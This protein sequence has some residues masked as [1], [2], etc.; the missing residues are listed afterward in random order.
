MKT[1]SGRWL[2]V[3]FLFIILWLTGCE[4]DDPGQPPTSPPQTATATVAT[5][6]AA[7]VEQRPENFYLIATDAPSRDGTFTD[8]DEFG[9]L[10]GYD[11]ELMALLA[12]QAGFEYEF[13]VT[14]LNGLFPAVA[15]GE[16]D[17]VMGALIIEDQPPEGIVYSEPYQEL[18]QMLVVRANEIAIQGPAGIGPGMR[19][20]VVANSPG[21]ATARSV[22][23]VADADLVL[24]MS[25]A[26]AAQALVNG[27]VVAVV[28][29]HMDAAFYTETYYQ[30]L[31]IAGNQT[32]RNAW[33]S[34]RA[35]G[36][37]VAAEN[38]DLLER[39]N[40]AIEALQSQPDYSQLQMNWLARQVAIVPGESLIG[41]PSDEVVI[42]TTQALSDL[43]PA[44]TVPNLLSWEVKL[45]TMTGLFRFD[46]DNNLDPVLVEF[47]NVQDEGLIY[48]ISLKPDL[49]FPDGSAL[50]A[51]D[52]QFSF[53]R[54]IRQGNFLLNGFLKDSDDDG[55]ADTDSIE[56]LGELSLRLVLDKPISYFTSV[57]ATTPYFIVSKDC[58]P[59]GLAETSTCGGLGPY[60]IKEWLPGESLRLEANPDWPGRAPATP[61]IQIRF[62]PNSEALRT[63]L[64]NEAID[65]AWNGLS[66]A[67]GAELE[68]G[69]FLGWNGPTVFKSYLVLVED[70]PEDPPAERSPW[71]DPRVKQA[72]AMSLDREALASQIFGESRIPL[73]GPI[74][75]GVPGYAEQTQTRNLEE[76]RVIL[77][78]AGYSAGDPLSFTLHY[79][80]DGRYTAL[81]GEYAAL[82]KAQLEETGLIEVTLE[83]APWETFRPGSSSCEYSAFLLG[84]PPVGQPA[85][86]NDGMYWME[87]F[88]TNTE[89]VCSHYESEQM[90]E[91][92]V[93]AEA[94]DAMPDRPEARY[95][96]YA[97][98]QAL[99]ATTLPTIDLTQEF[100]YA[101]TAS[102][103][104]SLR[105]DTMGLLRYDTI[106]K[107]DPS[108]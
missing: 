58:F 53:L 64:E 57:L 36:I 87:Y 13:V 39:L 67:E 59:E 106:G 102:T 35:Y 103:V 79:L 82:I 27:D 61:R 60:L 8:I 17:M 76:A 63:A 107:Q 91:L 20:G 46:A 6:T 66:R 96:L 50:T 1:L 69:T 99:W 4:G 55:F 37:A 12:D 100:S 72:I 16:F 75:D 52:V 86:F 81:E 7:V 34:S 105:I 62:Y 19:V 47:I 42:G 65:I 14:N 40:G 54:A 31:K 30:Q 74:P 33:L 70:D 68:A 94:A 44:A 104:S 11:A 18:G 83:G 5:P 80:N 22:L 78:A 93:Q 38:V 77:Q 3:P 26:S 90:A 89:R 97:Q 43:D 101:L 2:F 85:N 51:E 45:N 10:V 41:T 84:W 29:N 9:T 92:L 71:N 73:Y 108:G 25:A 56:L 21:E 88:I 32:G 98:M 24:Y 15:A 49:T 95:A 23:N 48:T 28:L